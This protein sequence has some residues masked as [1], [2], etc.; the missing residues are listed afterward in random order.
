MVIDTVVLQPLSIRTSVQQL[1]DPYTAVPV[2]VESME[3]RN[4]LAAH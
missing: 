3:Q 1:L 2:L 4:M